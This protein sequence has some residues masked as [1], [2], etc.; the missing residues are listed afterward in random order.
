MGETNGPN[1]I[2][3]F[4]WCAREDRYVLEQ[5]T[6]LDFHSARSLKQ[7]STDKH[8]KPLRQRILIPTPYCCQQCAILFFVLHNNV[9]LSQ[10]IVSL[11]KEIYCKTVFILYKN[12]AKRCHILIT[13]KNIPVFQEPKETVEQVV[14]PQWTQTDKQ[15]WLKLQSCIGMFLYVMRNM[16]TQWR[17]NSVS[18]K[19]PCPK[20]VENSWCSKYKVTF[21]YFSDPV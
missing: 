16:F 17:L 14:S 6:L 12:L 20:D 2:N 19:R 8:V 18:L 11:Y 7:K 4:N 3:T 1:N 5:H 10:L 9:H 13:A 21:V 15:L